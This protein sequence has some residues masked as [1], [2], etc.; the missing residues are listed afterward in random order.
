ME[1]QFN[2]L[3]D[4]NK[5]AVLQM[6]HDTHRQEIMHH[7]EM[8]FRAFS[9]TNGLFLAVTAA[10]VTFGTVWAQYRQ[11]G[12]PV[13]TV[14][15]FVISLS[16]LFLLRRNQNALETNARII[17]QIDVQ[18]GLFEKGYYGSDEAIYPQSWLEWGRQRKASIETWFYMA[19]TATVGLM[20]IVVAWVLS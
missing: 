3:N 1:Q 4:E 12:A 2:H 11:I 13:L 15:V 17:I 10:L 20:I 9:W 14:I 7:R 16:T 18:L 5:V 8:Q 6:A 19:T